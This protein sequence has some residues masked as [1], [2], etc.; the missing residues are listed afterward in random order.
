[1]LLLLDFDKLL[2][3]LFCAWLYSNYYTYKK[4]TVYIGLNIISDFRLLLRILKYPS[5]IRL[6]TGI[7]ENDGGG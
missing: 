4:K 7:K 5:K 6:G 2:V 1:V 3:I